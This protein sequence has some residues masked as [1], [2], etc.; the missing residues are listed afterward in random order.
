MYR[1]GCWLERKKK[2][3]FCTYL[4]VAL[5]SPL[6][7]SFGRNLYDYEGCAVATCKRPFDMKL[8]TLNKAKHSHEII[9]CVFIVIHSETWWFHWHTR[10]P[11]R[12][13]LKSIRKVW[14]SISEHINSVTGHNGPSINYLLIRSVNMQGKVRPELMVFIS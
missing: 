14:K 3:F 5:P 8:F 11:S 7:G 6:W 13:D 10:P 1:A 2:W 4:C 12:F 9:K